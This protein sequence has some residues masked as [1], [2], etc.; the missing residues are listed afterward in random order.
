MSVLIAIPAH[1]RERLVRF[2][3]ATVARMERPAGSELLLI[4]DA[5]RTFDPVAA[6]ADAGLTVTLQRHGFRVGADATTWLAMTR[7]GSSEHSHLLFVDSDMVVNT[8]ALSDGLALLAHYDGLLSLYNS[9]MHEGL[10]SEG[11]IVRKRALGNA[12]TLWRRDLVELVLKGLPPGAYLDDR[13]CTFLGERGIPVA[14]VAR[15]RMQHLG[16][17]GSN[18][19]YFGKLEHGI[20]FVPDEAHQTAALLSVYDDLLMR[21]AYFAAPSRR[22]KT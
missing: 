1:E 11:E 6:A 2:C 9:M 19:R 15:S 7:L 12:G 10:E 21:Q 18:N 4:D 16:F 3:L 17:E 22:Q 13:Y 14:S 8:T 5:C 20:G